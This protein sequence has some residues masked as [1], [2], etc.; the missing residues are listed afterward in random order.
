HADVVV[1]LTSAQR[2]ADAVPWEVLGGIDRRGSEILY[3]LN[4]LSR[5]AS[6][7]VSDYAALLRRHG[8][9]AGPGDPA[10]IPVQEQR[11]RGEAAA[12]PAKAVSRLTDALRDIA[13][14]RVDVMSDITSRAVAHCV[15]EAEAVAAGV[16]AQHEERL[17]LEAVVDRV[18]EDAF[19]E[20]TSELDGGSLIRPEVIE[21]WA[22]RVGPRD[23]ARWSNG[24]ASGLKNVADRLSG[25]P[26][27][28]VGRIER[29]ARRELADAVT[30]RLERAARAVGTA[31]EVDDAGRALLTPD[32]RAAGGD[33][34]DDTEAVIDRWLASLASTGVNAAAV[35]PI[36][37]VF[38]A[39][40]GLTGAEFGVAAG[41][42]AAQQGILEHVLGQAAA[43]SLAGSARDSFL[44]AVRQVFSAEKGRY[45]RV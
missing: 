16:L 37:A 4:R 1:F 23:V 45:R 20:L 24:S 17:R 33:V 2:Y 27:A 19:D 21:R 10:V 13:R 34:S 15:D 6:G 7:A 39:A 22:E 5:R 36:L 3:V 8:L 11:V 9:A 43:R 31:W 38:S 42:A 18:Y 26:A 35:A 12:L 30:V 44:D 32:L 41:A 40:G 29:E 25:Q 14:R 28:E